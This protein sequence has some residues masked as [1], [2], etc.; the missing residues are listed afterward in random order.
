MALTS[1]EAMGLMGIGVGDAPCP[2]AEQAAGIV[3]CTDPCQAGTAACQSSASPTYTTVP[4]S[5]G[6]YQVLSTGQV[7][8]PNGNLVNLTS[9]QLSQLLQ[10]G[11]AAVPMATTPAAAA[12]PGT[13]MAAPS[14]PTSWLIGGAAL[15]LLLV[16]FS[17]GG[18]RRR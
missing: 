12:I 11:A 18:G 7:Y 4:T 8:D 10:T 14:I 1:R 16:M 9:T 6:D 3:D 15:V 17:G 2:S 13:A 5:G